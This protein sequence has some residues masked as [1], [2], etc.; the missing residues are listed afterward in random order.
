MPRT[1]RKQRYSLDLNKSLDSEIIM[2]SGVTGIQSD[3]IELVHYTNEIQSIQ[4]GAFVYSMV[5]NTV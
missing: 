3:D 2:D 1:V 4:L 5:N